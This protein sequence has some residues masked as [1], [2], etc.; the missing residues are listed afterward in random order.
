MY[1]NATYLN[2]RASEPFEEDLQGRFQDTNYLNFAEILYT[3]W[4]VVEKTERFIYL[5]CII[6][7]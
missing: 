6:Y 1:L 7:T 4:V 3:T 5:L 2:Q